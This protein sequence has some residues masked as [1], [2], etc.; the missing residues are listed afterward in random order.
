MVERRDCNKSL[1]GVVAHL[2]TRRHGLHETQANC[3][4]ANSLAWIAMLHALAVG[5]PVIAR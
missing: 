4:I 2:V 1:T 3:C 5:E